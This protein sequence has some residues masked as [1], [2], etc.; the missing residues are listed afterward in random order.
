ME[1]ARIGVGIR[2]ALV[3]G[4]LLAML[5]LCAGP[6]GAATPAPGLTVDSFATPTNFSSDHNSVCV[7]DLKCDAY[8]VTVTNAGS[9]STEGEI[10][11]DDTLPPGLTPQ[12]ISFA[13][14]G[15]EGDLATSLCTMG[16][17]IHC[18]FPLALAPDATL[19]LI[20]DVTVSETPGSLTN[21]VAVSGGGSLEASTSKQ[22]RI[23]PT[24]PA[25]GMSNF[26][27]YIAGLDGANDAQAGD[28]PYEV[29]TTIGLANEFREIPSGNGGPDEIH[30]SQ[31]ADLKDVVVDLPLGFTGST[32]AAP[33][34]TLAQLSGDNCPPDT[35]VGHLLTEPN[36]QTSVDSPIWNLVPERGV[37]AEFGYVDGLHG[38][39]V[40][41]VSVVPTSAGY[42]LQVTNPDIP[43][44][45]MTHITATFFGN[46]AAKDETR[47][48]QIP[49]FTDPSDCSGGPLLASIHMDSWQK[50]GSYN[51]DGTPNFNDPNW[52]GAK[53]QSPSVTGCNSLRFTPEI[54]AQPTTK[55]ADTPSGLDFEIKVPQTEDVNVL[56][57][58]TMK[59]AVVTL[60]EG[61]TVDPSAGDGLGACTV[62]QIGWLG[63]TAKN[64]SPAQPSCPEASKI[65]S[66]E[67]TTPLIPGVLTGEM[68]LASQEENPFHTLLAAYVVVHDPVTGV[69]IKIA[70][71]F[72]PDPRTGRITAVFD[73]NPQLPFSD[74]KLHFFGG[75]RA[76]LATP[77]SCGTFTTNTELMP[78]SA[79]DS[80]P[81]GTPF[82]SFLIDESCSFGFSPS[83]TGGSTNL[84]AGAYT[85]F[86]ASFSRSDTDQELAG[87]T[88]SLPPGLLA[89]LTGMPLCSDTDANAGTC[90]AS[91]QVGSV[92][93]GVG[94]GPN[95]L[96]VS[97]KA[98]LTGPY[99]GGP[100][101]LA[102]VVPA[103][104]GPFNFGTVV[105][106]QSIRIDP[107]D[108]HVTDV[109]DPFP[110]IIDGIPLRLRRVD[111]RLERS[112][113]TFNPSSCSKLAFNGSISG[114]PLGA[115]RTLNGSVGYASQPG[116]R[117]DFTTPFQVTNCATL[118]F[119]P[120]FKVST[121]GKTSRKDGAS[122]RAALTYPNAAFGSQANIKSVKVD[123]PKQLPS[124]LT[125]LQKACTAAQFN[126]N[127]A[128]CPAASLIGHATVHTPILPFPLTGPAI[129]VS[130]GGEAFPSLTMV[131]QG[132]GVTVD[133]TGSTF[134]SKSGIT[135]TTF[136][137]VPD[138]PFSAFELTLPQGK[139]SALAAN[140]NLCKSKLAMPTELLAQNGVKINQSTKIAVTGCPKIRTAIGKLAS[141][142]RACHKKHGTKRASCERTA[143]R[144]FRTVK[145]S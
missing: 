136:R 141:A 81:V 14:S 144:K 114:S 45:Y 138:T 94:P 84:Q 102:V 142:L 48:P 56:A 15:L 115:P 80:G 89:N 77:Q 110:T 24:P 123:L 35:V 113:F 17:P 139:Y 96:F 34:C 97:G 1:T 29:T 58:P 129:F 19:K 108:A 109:S 30:D 31:V 71:E 57:T 69:L 79:P 78:W 106:R 12:K 62:A 145:K 70:G 33:T 67:L 119:K 22:N 98:Y 75:P 128:G 43:Q 82:D 118:G 44:V 72:L 73:E 9:Q 59:K 26:D 28:H 41:Y 83:F 4:G 131:L 6:A 140:G 53:S 40:F 112:R 23:D 87:L 5:A 116:A 54:V 121:Q 32:L 10:S 105:V 36:N 49:F 126:T 137:S 64:F 13:W 101:G 60:P 8:H 18:S 93:T 111:V 92:L 66:L 21:T 132:N 55:A 120:Q 39:H 74:L 51:A 27:F 20:V 68:F 85:P 143:R 7:S 88:L 103:V 37:P 95:P 11:I 42:V 100:Y 99:N 124:R 63:G 47:H 3:L 65:G 2:L 127:P 16:T 122:L 125:T 91:T 50:P 130:H 90:P 46:P 25:F 52:V 133:L 76:E 38:S 86:V 104:A 107:V 61:F 134:I 135:S 117:S